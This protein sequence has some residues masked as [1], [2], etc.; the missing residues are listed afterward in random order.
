[1]EY[2]LNHA[3]FCETD[4]L[5]GELP[6]DVMWWVDLCERHPT[7]LF[8]RK[9]LLDECR[10]ADLGAEVIKQSFNVNTLI[11]LELLAALPKIQA[12]LLAAQFGLREEIFQLNEILWRY[13]TARSSS[14][15]Q[16]NPKKM[17]KLH[18]TVSDKIIALRDA[19]DQMCNDI[20]NNVVYLSR[21]TKRGLQLASVRIGS[22]ISKLDGI[23][24]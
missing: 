9:G 8:A 22:F 6:K 17:K 10:K 18:S 3:N 14:E 15:Q 11:I 20:E 12:N 4:E 2:S 1:M 16:D 7:C 21:H 19:V 24:R 5:L 13:L 23:E